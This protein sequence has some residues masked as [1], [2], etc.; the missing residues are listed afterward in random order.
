VWSGSRYVK[1]SAQY[2][3]GRDQKTRDMP[4]GGRREAVPRHDSTES[5]DSF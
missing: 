5:K 2:P 4:P 3:L 1:P